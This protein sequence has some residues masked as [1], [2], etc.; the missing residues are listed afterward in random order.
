MSESK[1]AVEIGQ[2]PPVEELSISNVTAFG[3]GTPPVEKGLR[4]G[5]TIPV[6]APLLLM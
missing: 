3:S 2:S 4:L 6:T 1:A 5:F